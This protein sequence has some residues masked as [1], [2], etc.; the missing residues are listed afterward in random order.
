MDPGN[1]ALHGQQLLLAHVT[2]A[3]ICLGYIP[4]FL[5]PWAD[6]M[7]SLQCGW[8]LRNVAWT[9]C[10][11][12]LYK[13][14]GVVSCPSSLSAALA[15]VIGRIVFRRLDTLCGRTG[16]MFLYRH[17]LHDLSLDSPAFILEACSSYSPQAHF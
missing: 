10:N 6:G 11:V 2:T 15:I 17:W 4:S 8:A 9:L 12:V 5:H 14:P 16:F 1:A 13:F 3:I 7:D